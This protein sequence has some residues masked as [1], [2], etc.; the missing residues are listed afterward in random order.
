MDEQL[1]ECKYY[2]SSM[3]KGLSKVIEVQDIL[4][5]VYTLNHS[6]SK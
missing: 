3:R 4:W 1:C 6:A 2:H 5:V